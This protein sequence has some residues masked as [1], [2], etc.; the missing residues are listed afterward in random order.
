MLFSFH[1]LLQWRHCFG[2]VIKCFEAIVVIVL[3]EVI[4]RSVIV[5][6]DLLQCYCCG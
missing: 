3:L 5:V 1:R 2:L 6:G 4:Y